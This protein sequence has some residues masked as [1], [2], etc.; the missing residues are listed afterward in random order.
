MD[1]KGRERRRKGRR[2][3]GRKGKKGKGWERRSRGEE[4]EEVEE[5]CGRRGKENVDSTQFDYLV[6]ILSFQ[7]KC[8][9]MSK[10][11]FAFLQAN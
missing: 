10:V 3:G 5:E 2:E 9:S 4:R 6:I 8:S 7:T 1:G 11:D